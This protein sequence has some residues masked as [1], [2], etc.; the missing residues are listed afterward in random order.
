MIYCALNAILAV[1]LWLC[2]M[3][4]FD[5]LCHAYGTMATGGFSTF[6]TSLGHFD[7]APIDYTVTAFM[8]LAGTNFT[9]LY[10]L[11]LL[12]PKKILAT[13]SG[14]PTWP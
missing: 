2:G 14:G 6:N 3:S 11:C 8:V 1:L 13:S 10:L 7:S 9:L 5:A 12:R 4:W